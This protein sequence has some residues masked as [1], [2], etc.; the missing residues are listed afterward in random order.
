M[1]TRTP[2]SKPDGGILQVADNKSAFHHYEILDKFEAGLA[3]I[4]SEVKSIR[5]G[6]ASLKESY[7]QVKDQ[8]LFLINCHIAPYAQSRVDAH[9]PTREKK[10]LMH[11]REIEK[12]G[13]QIRQKGLT[14]LPLRMYL[15]RGRVKIE[16]AVGRGKKLHDKRADIKKREA[17][18]EINRAMRRNQRD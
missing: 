6:G 11:K 1:A 10:L 8:E 2:K 18:R 3:L 5:L 14:L 7:I 12:L 15:K 13:I 16:L 4:G 17:D 9:A